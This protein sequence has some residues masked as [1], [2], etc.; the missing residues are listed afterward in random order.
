M[1]NH[2]RLMFRGNIEEVTDIDEYL[3]AEEVRYDA[4]VE[5]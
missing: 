3:N 5:S 4:E 1:A 2:S